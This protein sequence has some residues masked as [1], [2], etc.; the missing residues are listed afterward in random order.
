M[1]NFTLAVNIISWYQL[2]YIKFRTTNWKS[3][4]KVQAA[5]VWDK[6]ISKHGQH[7]LNTRKWLPKS[8]FLSELQELE[9]RICVLPISS[10]I[11]L[12]LLT[13]FHELA[14]SIGAKHQ[15]VRFPDWAAW[16]SFSQ[17]HQ[18]KITKHSPLSICTPLFSL[19]HNH[20]LWP[21]IE[22]SCQYIFS[23]DNNHAFNDFLWYV[24]F[25]KLLVMEWQW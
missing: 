11:I 20:M 19:L 14:M 6:F 8:F 18:V 16:L 25:V 2:V 13:A 15:W 4:S 10:I 23:V 12:I 5:R 3:T 1:L 24:I 22:Q 7:I 21:S 9:V 17:L